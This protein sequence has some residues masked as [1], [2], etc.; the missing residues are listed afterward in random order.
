MVLNELIITKQPSQEKIVVYNNEIM[1]KKSI[2]IAAV[3]E[4]INNALDFA[5]VENIY[6]DV[7]IDAAFHFYLVKY[8]TDIDMENS[9]VYEGYDMLRDSGILDQVMAII[10]KDTYDAMFNYLECVKFSKEKRLMSFEGSIGRLL[11]TL[12]EQIDN[13]NNAMANFD[14]SNFQ[15]ALQFATA[16]NGGNDIFSPQ[17]TEQTNSNITMMPG[18]DSAE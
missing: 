10:P 9:N 1:V 17:E 12:P 4:L 16:A 13:I 18:V 8:F 14:P 6:N 2:S 7:R 5:L 3:E 11:A 15:E